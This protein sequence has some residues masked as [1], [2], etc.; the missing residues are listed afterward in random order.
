MPAFDTPEPISVTLDMGSGDVQVIAEDRTDTLVEVRPADANDSSD[1]KAAEQAS[2]EFDG[3]VLV[4]KTQKPRAMSRKS[5][6]VDVSIVLP[7][8][9]H[10]RGE[11][12]MGDLRCSGR[13]G[14]CNFKTPAGHIQ[15][16]H[17]SSMR[18]KTSA[19]D[20]I[21]GR[22]DGAAEVN[23]ANGRLRIGEIG[24]TAEVRNSNGSTEIGKVIG[25]ITVRCSNSQ[26]SI[27][28]ALGSTTDAATSNGSIRVGEVTHGTVV[29]KT[30]AGDLE[31]G[32][33]A[34]HPAKL[35]LT[36]GFGRVHNMLENTVESSEKSIGVRAHTSYG[37][38][39]I[40]RA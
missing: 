35:D 7:T 4:I 16:D 9:S 31:V 5:W 22:V 6:T 3:R 32:I 29:L 8:G 12:A 38:I 15:L 30:S 21:V 25:D 24:G 2:V 20:I 18:V 27:D 10:V 39:R 28:H 34:G 23:T 17:V 40:K 36:T 11:V 1:V 33:G 14:G 13:L 26:I 37:D 19:G